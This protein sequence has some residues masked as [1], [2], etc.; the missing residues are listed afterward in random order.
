MNNT[1]IPINTVENLLKDKLK[2][3]LVFS[4]GTILGSM[5][6]MPHELSYTVFTDYLDRNIG[7]P[8]LCPGLQDIESECISMLSSLLSGNCA[9]GSLVTGGTEA[10]ILAMWTMKELFPQK[11][12]V[13]LPETAHFSFDKAARMLGLELVKIAVDD[14]YRVIADHVE[15]A[16]DENTAGIVGIAGTTG[17]GT[18]DPIRKLSE[19]AE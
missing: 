13:I 7:D 18:V 1:G 15:K 3:D 17:L 10:N 19:I 9:E 5:C 8:G 12:K 6:S 14:Q 4:N 11:N 16:I 2:T